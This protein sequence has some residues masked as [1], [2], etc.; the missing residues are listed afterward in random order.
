MA[1]TVALDDERRA[2]L[3]EFVENS[4]M[5]DEVKTR[6]KAQLAEPEV[7]AEMVARLERRM[8]T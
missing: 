5:P 8:G 4:R 2:K 6:M 1:E 7:P 3:L